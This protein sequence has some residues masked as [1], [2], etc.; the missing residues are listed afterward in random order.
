MS[1][2]LKDMIKRNAEDKTSEYPAGETQLN[3]SELIDEYS[4]KSETELMET[5]KAVVSEQ[6]QNGVFDSVQ[7]E[8]MIQNI[9][10]MLNEEQAKKFNAI[11]KFLE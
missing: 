3:V 11:L 5:L 6:K 10:P 2:S 4:G 7:T 8:I 1:K 9:M